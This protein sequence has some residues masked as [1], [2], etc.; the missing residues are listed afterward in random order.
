MRRLCLVL[1]VLARFCVAQQPDVRVRLLSL[2]HLSEVKIEPL[3]PVKLGRSNMHKA[4]AARVAAGM[5]EADG[6]TSQN[7]SVF[8]DFRVVAAPAPPQH[9]RGKLE[10]SVKDNVLWMVATLPVERYVTAVLQGETAGAMPPEAL[11]AMAVAIRSYTARFRERHKSDGFDLCD[12]T[13]CQFLRLQT[14][15]AVEAAVDETAGETLWN[16]GSPLAAYYHQDC[17]GQTESAA[18][19]WHD[20][21]SEMLNSHDDP[22]CVRVAR[23][24]RSEVSQADLERALARADLHA[25][26]HWDRIAIVQRTPS[27]RARNL[28]FSVGGQSSVLVSASSLRFAVGRTLGWMTLKS[29]WYEI[30]KQGDHFIFSGKGVGHGVGMCQIG[31]AEMARQGKNYHEILAFYYPGAAEGRSAKGIAWTFVEGD[32]F[33]LRVVNADDAAPVREAGGIALQWARQRSG[34]KMP[35]RPVLEVFPAV[36]MFRDTTGEPG[37]VAASTR[38][39]R[40]R[41]QPPSVLRDRLEGILRHEFLHMLIEG[42]AAAATPLWFREGVVVHLGGEPAAASRVEMSTSEIDR[43]IRSRA[44]QFEM[45]RAYAQA[46]ARVRD[47]EQKH[48]RAHLMEWLSRGLPDGL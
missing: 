15:A 39:Q 26:P 11:K 37:W 25:P 24:W 1:L 41:L 40:V 19:A 20:Q 34:L 2:F 44:G 21:Q 3:G 12:T 33:D 13:H 38:H 32:G 31:A 9:V 18:A 36:A 29:D 8:G 4:F 48:G 16:H 43:V 27:G 17:G 7:I 6:H 5:V 46:G 10:I 22:Y 30:T 14:Q 28:S 35:A 42:H 45:R 47:L 23:H